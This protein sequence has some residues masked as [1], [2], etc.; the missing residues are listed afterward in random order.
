M[1]DRSLVV[2][3]RRLSR[4]L[5]LP[6]RSAD[7]LLQRA[8]GCVVIRAAQ[9]ER[10]RRCARPRSRGGAA[11]PTRA[12]RVLCAC[13]RSCSTDRAGRLDRLPARRSERHRDV[14]DRVRALG[15]LATLLQLSEPASQRY[16]SSCIRVRQAGPSADLTSAAGTAASSLSARRCRGRDPRPSY[17]L[18][19]YRETQRSRERRPRSER[20]RKS[21]GLH[22]VSR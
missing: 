1:A 7:G 3:L 4:L 12:S 18:P 9:A 17:R 15:R 14:P 21:T 16:A 6:R 11:A 2:E 13:L 10:C 8:L 19:V 5:S 20:T 22:G